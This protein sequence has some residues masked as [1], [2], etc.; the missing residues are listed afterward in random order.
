VG[1]V[2]GFLRLSTRRGVLPRPM[3]PDTA[4]DVVGEWVAHPLVTL[5]LPGDDHW[6]ILR[7]LLESTGTGGN[8][9]TD[10]HLAAL[11]L[12][13]DAALYSTDGTSPDSGR[14]GWSTRSVDTSRRTRRPQRGRAGAALAIVAPQDTPAPVST[15]CRG[16]VT[17]RSI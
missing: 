1:V 5:L 13:Y 15:P 2:L 17:P 4:L 8:L 12:E 16:A 9:T 6:G 10:A 11:A 14:S 3:A 7:G